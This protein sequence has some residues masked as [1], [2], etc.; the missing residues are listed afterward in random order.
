MKILIAADMEG[1]TG[2]TRWE[3]TESKHAEY[4]RFRR[5]LGRLPAWLSRLRR[6]LA[7]KAPEEPPF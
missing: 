5:I 2:V 4:S 7:G 6:R 1:V 3:E